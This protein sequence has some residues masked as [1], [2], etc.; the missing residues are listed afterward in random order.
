MVEEQ[1]EN[2]EVQ[3]NLGEIFSY[4]LQKWVIILIVF[5]IGAIGGFAV[6]SILPEYYTETAAYVLSYNGSDGNLVDQTNAQSSVSKILV[7]CQKFTE[8]NIFQQTV[9]DMLKDDYGY[10]FTVKEIAEIM[11]FEASTSSSTTSGNFI[12]VTVKTKS[13]QQ[14]YDIMKTI[15]SMYPDFIKENYKMANDEKLEFSLMTSLVAVDELE[16]VRTLGRAACTIIGAL[17]C[18]VVALI[19]LAI[20]CMTDSRVKTETE[21]TE[22]YGAAILASIPDYYDKNLTGGTTANAASLAHGIVRKQ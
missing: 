5:V 1:Q 16:G 13:A 20:I 7:G 14:S 6:G 17:G 19:V 4:Y 21:L 3:I 11:T 18:T 10:E 8:Y 9:I 12:E 22:K 2:E 15:I